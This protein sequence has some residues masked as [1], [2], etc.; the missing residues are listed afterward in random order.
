MKDG[1]DPADEIT[2]PYPVPPA[3]GDAIEIAPGLLWARMPLPV[4]LDHVNVWLLEE[5]DGWTAVD[6]GLDSPETRAAWEKLAAGPLRGRPLRRLVATHAHVDHVGL[7]GWITSRFQVPF[8]ATRSA[9][10]WARVVYAGRNEPTSAQA[11]EHLR[12]HG[13][14]PR[15]IEAYAQNRG[16]LA[17]LFG[18]PP[19]AFARL[20]DGDTLEMGDRRW[21]V[22][23]ADGHADEHASFLGADD[24]IV[25][26]GDQVLQRISPVVGVFSGEPHAD[27]L[28]A[29]LASLERFRGVAAATLVLPSHGL[30]FRGLD[31]RLS[32]LE[33]HHRRRLELALGALDWPRTAAECAQVLFARA[34]A[35]G[36]WF[37]ALAETLAHLHR[38]EAMG[39]A[40]REVDGDG[41]VRFARS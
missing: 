30:P 17:R 33:Q 19:K 2:L 20:R 23:T 36:Q 34:L 40:R 1:I 24:D 16:P 31:A 9:W 10:L 14:D 39:A 4:R 32:Q 18:E 5:G 29:F 11:L 7:A 27:P 38:L 13:C 6:C 3:P 35:E 8:E 37:L 12:A 25:I 15:H 28:A 22:L 26:A 21:R 41:L